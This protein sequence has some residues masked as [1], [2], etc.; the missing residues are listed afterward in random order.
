MNGPKILTFKKPFLSLFAKKFFDCVKIFLCG[1]LFIEIFCGKFQPFWKSSLIMEKFLEC[2]KF[3][4]L[5]KNSLIAEK[6]FDCE[7]FAGLWKN[8]LTAEKLLACGK[9]P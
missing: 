5:W 8:S 7:K 1:K 6:F 4:Q 9:F 3:P 2:R